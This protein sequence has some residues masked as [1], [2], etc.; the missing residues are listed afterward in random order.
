MVIPSEHIT[1]YIV[2]F[3]SAVTSVP[4]YGFSPTVQWSFTS[5]R[6]GLLVQKGPHGI[7]SCLPL[8][9]WIDVKCQDTLKYIC[10]FY[11]FSTLR[12][13]SHSKHKDWFSLHIWYHGCWCLSNKR[14]R[15]SA[16]KILMTKLSQNILLSTLQ[17][18]RCS[19]L[20]P[21][22][23]AD[24][25]DKQESKLWKIW[26]PTKRHDHVIKWKHFPRYWPFVRRIHRSPVN[27]THK[28]QWRGALMFFL[29]AP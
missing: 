5:C 7:L 16:A 9:Y 27:S 19:N 26:K 13:W 18:L 29:S 22:R 10:I 15:A 11:H 6:R 21:A 14:R 4:V 23:P 24:L 25:M 28:G 17:G 2:A 1:I 20:E 12:C 8:W 3:I